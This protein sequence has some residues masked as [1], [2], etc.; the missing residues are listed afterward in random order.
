[1]LHDSVVDADIVDQAGPEAAWLQIL[2]APDIG[3]SSRWPLT[4]KK[5]K[6]N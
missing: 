4:P 5:I 6:K 1:L 2:A 3:A